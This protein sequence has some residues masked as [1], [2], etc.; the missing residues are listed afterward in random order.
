MSHPNRLA[1]IHHPFGVIAGRAEIT[2]TRDPNG[3]TM[4]EE[5]INLP[6][7]TWAMQDIDG[8]CWISWGEYGP[9]APLVFPPS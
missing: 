3:E 8:L 6:P 2:A 5:T 4:V 1:R 9:W 7:G